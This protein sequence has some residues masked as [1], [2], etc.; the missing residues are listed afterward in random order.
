MRVLA[1]DTSTPRAFAAAV[2]HGTLIHVATSD[3]P[4]THAER[5]LGLV[6]EVLDKSGWGAD[7]TQL[8]VVGKGPGSFTGVRVG[9]A[10]AKG[11]AFARRIPLVGVVSLD[12]I[13][14]GAQLVRGGQAGV[15]VMDARKGEVFA[16][17]YDESGRR[18]V[19]PTHLPRGSVQTWLGE[20]EAATRLTFRWMVGEVAGSLGIRP[21]LVMSSP[22]T[23]LPSPAAVAALGV[24]RWAATRLDELLVLDPLY[25][26]PPDITLPAAKSTPVDGSA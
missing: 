9:V 17:A 20:T 19:E 14:Y 11:W 13:A 24:E 18:V 23:D 5:L 15:A 3:K 21:D 25:V 4:T 1:L 22:A 7:G 10:T 2:E 6:R 12:A 16:A 26:R 8:V